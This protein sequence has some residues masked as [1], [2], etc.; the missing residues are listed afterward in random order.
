V[1][2]RSQF[3]NA[4]LGI[5]VL[6]I[7]FCQ[8]LIAQSISPSAD[9]HVNTAFPAVN[10]G[11]SPFL[12]V[13][14]TSTTYLQF[15]LSNLPAGFSLPAGSQVNLVLWVNR[16]GTAGT[17]QVSQGAGAW[18]EGSITANN[19]PGGT[20][21]PI[22][23][24]LSVTAGDQFI[25]L[26]VTSVVQQWLNNPV[27]NF[28]FVIAGVSGTDVFL[29]SKE[30]VTTSHQPLLQFVLA[31]PVG[32][33]GA[34]GANGAVGATGAT[35]AIGAV[36]AT[37][38]TG[39]TGANGA[40]G[41]TGVGTIGPTGPAGAGGFGLLFAA[42]VLNP[43]SADPQ[44]GFYFSPTASGDATV[45]GNWVLYSQASIT[46]PVACTFDSLYVN[47]GAVPG[48]LGAG[49]QITVTL[50]VQ[51]L[52][53]QNNSSTPMVVTVD[54]TNGPAAGNL[55]NGSVSVGPGDTISL[56]AT[57]AGI[58]NGQEIISTSLH[59]GVPLTF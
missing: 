46:M 14:G 40:V 18:T 33:T 4:L 58:S 1:P 55:T 17:V 51:P 35:G 3:R 34:T 15:P 36:G 23:S 54:N 52:G 37:G 16:I 6:C 45:G 38:A 13:G 22:G 19:L 53:S 47:A 25:Y 41:A 49:G 50:S 12:E 43:G 10:F 29:D 30:S 39:S 48:G 8:S 5:L 9:A 59:C 11:A 44:I 28:G 7:A 20:P 21:V 27:S 32:A 56:Q 42:N 24:P 31:G 26:D 57:G 2:Q